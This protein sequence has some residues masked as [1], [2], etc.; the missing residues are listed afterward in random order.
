[1]HPAK[2]HLIIGLVMLVAGTVATAVFC[3]SWRDRT[4]VAL[5]RLK[6]PVPLSNYSVTP[7][8]PVDFVF[9]EQFEPLGEPVSYEDDH[10][11]VSYLPVKAKGKKVGGDACQNVFLLSCDSDAADIDK[12]VAQG[13]FKGVLLQPIAKS[14]EFREYE[15]AIQAQYPDLD[16]REAAVVWF[17]TPP[18]SR[19][20]NS[21]MFAVGPLVGLV[22]FIGCYCHQMRHERK[23]RKRAEAFHHSDLSEFPKAVRLVHANPNL[24]PSSLAPR[25]IDHTY[26]V[27]AQLK[28][29]NPRARMIAWQTA[30]ALFSVGIVVAVQLLLLELGGNWN[31]GII[32]VMGGSVFFSVFQFFVHRKINAAN[33]SRQES[34]IKEKKARYRHIAFHQYHDKVLRELGFRDIGDYLLVSSSNARQIRTIYL[35]SQGNTL[36]EVGQDSH[37]D[38]FTIETL[39]N[40]GKFLETH[41]LLSKK[42]EQL[43]L[44]TRHLRRSAKHIDLLQALQEHDEFVN[45]RTYGGSVL[46][47]Q[48]TEERFERFLAW[49]SYKDNDP[50]IRPIPVGAG[51]GIQQR[52]NEGLS[53][54]S[55]HF[56]S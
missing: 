56:A 25:S 54:S 10:G 52:L 1:M 55:G 34:R 32:S 39:I 50:S 40:D 7:S 44:N 41:S 30:A 18:A 9:V 49:P 27:P 33:K 46:E 51:K 16:P 47:A 43:D 28:K 4:E 37:R 45:E 22:L 12:L 36:V 23:W 53:S 35:S 11:S 31:R 24:A 48:F 26:D 6:Q 3:S 21:M 29:A 8:G 2:R 5:D 42:Q 15:L 20:F 17:H 19:Q 13:T 14:K 38:Y